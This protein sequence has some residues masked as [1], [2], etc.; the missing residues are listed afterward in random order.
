MQLVLAAEIDPTTIALD[1]DG[2][3]NDIGKRTLWRRHRSL[4]KAGWVEEEV[5]ATG[6]GSG[7][8]TASTKGKEESG[9]TVQEEDTPAA[10]SNRGPARGRR[11][12]K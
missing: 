8:G 5:E 6:T 7:Y 12:Q 10:P 9:E 2:S 3:S 4:E 1:S 11:C